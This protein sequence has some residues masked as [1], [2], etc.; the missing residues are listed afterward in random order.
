MLRPMVGLRRQE[1]HR[2]RLVLLTPRRKCMR[3]LLVI[4][5]SPG[6]GGFRSVPV[7]SWQDEYRSDRAGSDDA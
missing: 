1:D 7:V 6:A 2:A 3:D 5:R 4:P